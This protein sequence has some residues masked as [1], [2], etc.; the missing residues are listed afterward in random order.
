VA[1]KKEYI[2]RI[3]W[4]KGKDEIK[5]LSEQFSDLDKF[6]FEVEGRVIEVPQAMNKYLDRC[7]DNLGVS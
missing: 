4:S 6:N 2:L 5:H 1:N 7:D 3:V